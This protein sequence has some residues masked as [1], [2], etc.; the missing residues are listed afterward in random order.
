[1]KRALML[2]LALGAAT[3]PAHACAGCAE[4][5]TVA[6]GQSGEVIAGF[7]WSV[8]FLL[9]TL[10]SGM[11]GMGALIVRTCRRL[12]RERGGAELAGS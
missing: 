1:M 4:A 6:A 3:L 11:G 12:D 7:S 9:G 8:L 2:L 5:V 10:L